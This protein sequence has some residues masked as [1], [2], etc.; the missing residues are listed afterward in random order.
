[1]A[2]NELQD[3]MLRALPP[4]DSRLR[5]D[6]RILEEGNIGNYQIYLNTYTPSQNECFQG[7]VLE[8]ACLSVH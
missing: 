4:T 5:P 2:L 8:S 7:G 3:Y 6:V 1:M